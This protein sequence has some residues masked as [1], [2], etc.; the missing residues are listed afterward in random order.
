M[1]ADKAREV[2][3]WLDGRDPGS[4]IDEV[5]SYARR[6]PGTYLAIALGAGLLAGRLTRGLTAASADSSGP[7]ADGSGELASRPV[8]GFEPAAG[9][10]PVAGLEP[11]SVPQ[12]VLDDFRPTPAIGYDGFGAAGNGGGNGLSGDPLR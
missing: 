11:I 2:A 5:R 3:Q 9:L 4:L 1:G 7:S 6:R 10:E 12:P 8:A